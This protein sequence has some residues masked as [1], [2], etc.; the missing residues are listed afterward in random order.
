MNTYTQMAE[1]TEHIDF[2]HLFNET[3]LLKL[4]TIQK[5]TYVLCYHDKKQRNKR[6]PN[7]S[8][9]TPCV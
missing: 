4:F 3:W 6:K 9:V 7:T 8:Y 2:H 5:R 1:S